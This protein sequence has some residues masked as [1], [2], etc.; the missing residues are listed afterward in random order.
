MQFLKI[1][2]IPTLLALSYFTIPEPSL[3]ANLVAT[4]A[5]GCI[6]LQV[7]FVRS[8]QL[9]GVYITDRRYRLLGQIANTMNFLWIIGTSYILFYPYSWIYSLN[10]IVPTVVGL[11]WLGKQT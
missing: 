11:I 9:Y 6:L 8:R 4:A 3:T 10:L 5:L 1:L 2:I 7:E